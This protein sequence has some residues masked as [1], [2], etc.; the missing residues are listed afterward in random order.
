MSRV[1]VKVCGTT[2]VADAHLAQEAGA[3]FLGIVI[4]HAAS[5]RC[6]SR[7]TARRIQRE[8]QIPIVALSVNRSIDWLMELHDYLQPYSL[9]LHG[10]EEPEMVRV[11]TSSSIRVWKALSGERETVKQQAKQFSDAG[12]EAILLDAR[13]TSNNK[14]VYGG[15]GHLSDWNLAREL[16]QNGTRLILAGGLGPDNVHEAIKAVEPWLVD[17]ASKLEAQKGTKD[18]EKV[19]AF[20]QIAKSF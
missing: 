6:V 4:E 5:P 13:Q 10:D 11:L 19:K 14:I 16:S 12:A 9:Q 3:D 7:E 17:S 1:L 20:V 15:T 18:A 2:N 8:V